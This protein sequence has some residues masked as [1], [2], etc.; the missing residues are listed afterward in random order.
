[1]IMIDLKVNFSLLFPVPDIPVS[2]RKRK[3]PLVYAKRGGPA[4]GGGSGV[5]K[6]FEYISK[7]TSIL[8]SVRADYKP[9]DDDGPLPDAAVVKLRRPRPLVYAKRGPKGSATVAVSR[10]FEY[11]SRLSD[12]V[13]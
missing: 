1:M 7:L 11:V 3:R 8:R 9:V 10:P 12:L 13:R 5:S 2:K 6:P 4:G